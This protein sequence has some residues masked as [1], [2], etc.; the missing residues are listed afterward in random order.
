MRLRSRSR[1]SINR[2]IERIKTEL[3]V[4]GG[5]VVLYCASNIVSNAYILHP[6]NVLANSDREVVTI[7][8]PVE[9]IKEIEVDRKFTS[10]KQQIMAYMIEKFGDNA[11]DAITIL[12]KCENSE[13]NPNAVNHNANGTCDVGVM[14][15]NTKCDSEEFEK[16]KD[17]KYNINR[18]YEKFKAG[19]GGK[20]RNTFYLWTCGYE[21]GDYTYYDRMQGK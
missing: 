19:D 17:W 2:R 15:I 20:Y 10:Q 16:L 11:D 13:F 1:L 14:Q 9:V 8:K 3:K 6:V 18:G 21:V 12:N 4:L 7:E 5:L